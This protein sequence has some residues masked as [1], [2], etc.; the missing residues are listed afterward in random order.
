MKKG[1]PSR[2]LKCIVVKP[3]TLDRYVI[4]LIASNKFLYTIKN[5]LTIKSTT[6]EELKKNL[7][8][9]I[10]FRKI[11]G[12]WRWKSWDKVNEYLKVN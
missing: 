9:A 6:I 10:N 11:W 8:L 12:G 1:K 2:Y 7:R 5:I 4:N 3:K